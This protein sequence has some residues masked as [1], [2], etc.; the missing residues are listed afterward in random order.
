[1]CEQRWRRGSRPVQQQL[2]STAMSVGE[3]PTQQ[4]PDRPTESRWR[5]SPLRLDS[6]HS[7]WMLPDDTGTAVGDRGECRH[8]SQRQR[9][10]ALN[11]PP[12]P[13]GSVY[14]M[15]TGSSTVDD[16]TGRPQFSPDRRAME[17]RSAGYPAGQGSVSA[18][19]QQ[20][21]DEEEARQRQLQQLH[22]Y[23][24][25]TAGSS[26]SRGEGR[27]SSPRSLVGS[28]HPTF[29]DPSFGHHHMAHHGH[30][31]YPC[32]SPAAASASSY[33]TGRS[34]SVERVPRRS[35]GAGGRATS[36]REPGLFGCAK[37]RR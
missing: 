36:R 18:A 17:L 34:F 10:L 19:A 22:G 25:H 30:P 16:G 15:H 5:T 3:E 35:A 14:S 1:M 7:D 29:S 32:A 27:P 28:A 31:P 13:R 6:V 37:R 23:R 8:I 24:S 26:S 4:A 20:R 12:S 9:L 11:P 33:D 2:Q 21:H